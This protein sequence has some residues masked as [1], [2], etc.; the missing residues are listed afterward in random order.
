VA[1]NPVVDQH[2]DSHGTAGIPGCRLDPQPFE[3]PLS[4]NAAIAHTIQSNPSGE[5]EVFLSCFP[6]HVLRH[7]QHHFFGDFLDRSSQIHLA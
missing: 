2:G 6:V 7:L 1:K 5:A 3:R 4:K